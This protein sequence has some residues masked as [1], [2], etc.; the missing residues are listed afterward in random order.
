MA[1]RGDRGDPLR[2]K[3]FSNHDYFVSEDAISPPPSFRSPG[4]WRGGTRGEYPGS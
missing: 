1:A 3:L 4:I 2:P